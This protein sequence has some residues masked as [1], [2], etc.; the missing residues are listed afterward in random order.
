[1]YPSLTTL[2]GDLFADLERQLDRLWNGSDWPPSIRAV[3]RGSFPAINMGATEEAIEIYAFAPGVDPSRIDVTFDKG[4]LAVTGERGSDAPERSGNVNL[5]AHERFTGT[6]K[7]VISLP[8]D[9]DA[10]KVEASYRDGVLK[11]VV[12]R[13][14]AAKPRRIEVKGGAHGNDH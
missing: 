14:E 11:V 8:E 2:P 12:P 10:S 5:Y 4:L 13:R 6:F 9:V 1:M 3:A 7:R